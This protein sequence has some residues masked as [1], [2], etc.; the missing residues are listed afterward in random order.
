MTRTLIALLLLAVA[1]PLA[2]QAPE[3]MPLET[4]R[5]GALAWWGSG[6]VSLMT[7]PMFSGTNVS[8]SAARRNLALRFSYDAASN[9]K[10][11]TTMSSVSVS[12]GVHNRHARRHLGALAGPALVS[13]QVTT[14]HDARGYPIIERY[15]MVGAVVEASA[16]YALWSSVALGIGGWAHVNSEVRTYGAG[17][18]LRIRLREER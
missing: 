2:A 11:T 10:A 1:G 12:V 5:P 13:A 18:M 3:P 8:L 15:L 9:F 16:L 7:R 4:G 6:G 14:G 17:P